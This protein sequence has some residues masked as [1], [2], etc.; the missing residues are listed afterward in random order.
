MNHPSCS[1]LIALSLASCLVGGR[2]ALAD[3]PR[4][5]VDLTATFRYDG[6]P[7]EREELK[8]DRDREALR[9]P[10]LSESLVVDKE[11]KGVA[12]V[13]VWL[14]MPK[15][16]AQPRIHPDDEAAAKEVREIAMRNA[17]FEPHIT[18]VRVGQQLKIRNYDK[19]GHN[20]KGSFFANHFLCDLLPADGTAQITFQKP[21]TH[22]MPVACNIH[23]WM[24]GWVLV[25]DNPFMAVSDS[26]G[27]LKIKNVPAST[28]TFVFWHEQVGFIKEMKRDG[29]K[30][31]AKN[32]RLTLAPGEF[33]LGEIV[34]KP[35][36]NN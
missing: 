30:I 7:P 15:D 10:I 23:P 11:T 24:N 12:N 29:K 36:R 21:E 34:I 9:L 6:D 17:T 2:L 26:Q 35:E 33:D 31:E 13:V 14:Y 18:T 32:G 22:L 3:E 19:I 20:A 4:E 27:K 25:R 8:V 5:W 28:H 1:L 16:A